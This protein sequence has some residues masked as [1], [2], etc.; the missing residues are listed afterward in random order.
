LEIKFDDNA[1]WLLNYLDTY[2]ALYNHHIIRTCW[3]KVDDDRFPVGIT[4][5]FDF[6]EIAPSIPTL[7]E[8]DSLIITETLSSKSSE[9]V[10]R[11]YTQLKQIP[12]LE[13]EIHFTHC[14]EIVNWGGMLYNHPYWKAPM[15]DDLGTAELRTS[16]SNDFVKGTKL[17]TKITT[18]LSF[19]D[20]QALSTWEIP[21][22]F[23]DFGIDVDRDFKSSRVSILF[24][25]VGIIDS[26]VVSASKLEVKGK[27]LRNVSD[28]LSL[29]V[30]IHWSDGSITRERQDIS[31]KQEDT[32]SIG[33]WVH[34]ISLV[35]NDKNA[36]SV[37]FVLSLEGG[38]QVDAKRHTVSISPDAPINIVSE[39]DSKFVGGTIFSDWGTSE[40]NLQKK[41]MQFEYFVQT[42]FNAIGLPTI[43]LGPHNQSGIDL[44]SFDFPTGHTYSLECT[45]GAPRRKA[46]LILQ[47]KRK[48][49]ELLPVRNLTTIMVTSK[50]VSDADRK[51][52]S[53]S[54]V[55][56]IDA[57]NLLRIIEL[58]KEGKRGVDIL[59]E[60]GITETT[61]SW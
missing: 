33:S 24:P 25:L 7:W 36:L 49:S 52:L 21:G 15:Y 41:I 54:D 3:V 47:A 55:H 44:I 39:L 18:E 8:S 9:D 34:E 2:G 23:R 22:L 35:S 58:A 19:H 32:S 5:R 60:I 13:G 27:A 28:K 12:Y 16:W 56:V 38:F 42:V 4:I 6:K 29:Y 40:E 45:T 31:V 57:D 61:S 46:S 48:L 53:E 37:Y 26:S 14:P 17:S 51:D 11:N 10:I 20:K 1:D 50:T 59:R 43:W 30:T